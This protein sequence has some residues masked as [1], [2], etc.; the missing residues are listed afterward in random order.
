MPGPA[1][2]VG[3]ATPAAPMAAAPASMATTNGH[4]PAAPP[5]DRPHVVVLGAGVCGLYAAHT[6][7]GRGA[8]VTVLE[9][10]EIVG[11][12]A[13]GRERNGNFYD[14]GVHQLHAFDAGVFEDIRALMGERLIPTQKAAL[15]R[16]GNGYRRYPLEF[17]D[18]LT[19]IPAW[20]LARAM[21]GLVAQ[22]VVN[23][24]RPGRA[25][26]NAEEA[27]IQLYGRPLY[28][29]FFRDFTHRYWGIPPA[30]L[31]ATFVRSKMPRL[32]AV[33][34]VKKA[35]ARFG[36]KDDADAAVESALRDETLWYSPTGARE[37]P[38]ALADAIAARGGEVR[39]DA[40]VSTV[41]V[42]DGAADGA[43]RIRAVRYTHDGGEHEVACDACLSTIPVSALVRALGEHAPADVA[44]AGAA[45]RHKAVAVYGL[46]VRKPRVLDA[47]YVYYRDRIFHRIA[48]PANSG[49]SVQPAGHTIVLVELTCDVGDDRWNGGE[50]TRRRIVAD[51][52]AEGLVA[53][54]D[55]VEWHVFADAHAYPV[56]D[57]GFEP[58]LARIEAHLAGFA[59]LRS[60]GRQGAFCFPNMHGAMRMGADAAVALL[61]GLGA[62]ARSAE[63][64]P[65]GVGDAAGV[66]A[67]SDGPPMPQPVGSG[68]PAPVGAPIAPA[69][70]R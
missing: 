18:L 7:A 57:L 63:R 12:L 55:I 39:L 16:Y 62:T 61:A 68:D 64:A 28:G 58:H 17:F 56:F 44:A 53:P 47:Q 6:L 26:A 38:M 60:T 37:M 20:T 9:K 67:G 13:G 66:A 69:A 40:A 23:R 46:L 35:L 65:S 15:I 30:E 3:A 5:A 14:F 22:Q 24:L 8:R 50:A 42:D 2:A 10:A 19:G 32:S 48:E 21:A 41:V 52:Q 1:P 25:P 43:R 70:V 27:L 59:N 29:F 49:M 33:D 4:H 51:M 34:I 11:G 45:L 54:E 36:V 31:S